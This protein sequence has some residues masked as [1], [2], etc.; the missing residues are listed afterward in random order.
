MLK[1]IKLGSKDIVFD[2]KQY[3]VSKSIKIILRRDGKLTVTAPLRL[4]ERAI[5]KFI[6][7][8]EQWIIA[9][10]DRLAALPARPV[11]DTRKKYLLHKKAAEELVKEK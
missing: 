9:A 11:V 8:K 6:L 4:G 5:A 7:K 3:R 1:K 10:L 2:L